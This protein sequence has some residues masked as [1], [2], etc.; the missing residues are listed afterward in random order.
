MV[1]D[2]SELTRGWSVS[3]WIEFHCKSV[4][5][6]SFDVLSKLLKSQK[7]APEDPAW[8]S[9]VSEAHLEHQWQILQS[10]S[11]KE[12]LPLYGVPIAVKDNIDV[13][14]VATTAACPAFSYQPSRDSKV[15]ELLRD[16][17]AVIIGKTNLDQF[18]TGLVGCR[19]PYGKTPCAFSDKHVSGGSSAG[20]G[21]VVARG[22]VPL[23]LGTDTAGSGRVPAAL[24]NLIG[25][26]PTKGVFSCQGVVPAC[27]SLD[28]V[29]IF[30][31]NLSNAE[32]A[33]KVMCQADERNDEYSRPYQTNPLQR[34]GSDVRVGIPNIL[35][36]FGETENPKLYASAVETLRSGGADVVTIDFE[37]L[38]ELARCLYEGAWVAERYEATKDFL[39]TNP[40]QDSLDPTVISIIKSG[41]KYSAADAFRFEYKR[42][43]ILRKVEALLATIDVLCV[44]TCPLNPTFDQVAKEPILVNSRQG[45]WTNFVNLAD[46]AALAIPAGF[47]PDGLPTGITLIGKKFTDYAL[48]DL[49]RRFFDKKYPD[50]TRNY[51]IFTEK[52]VGIK[53][54]ELT[55]PTL[56]P[57]QS[58]KLAVVGAHLKGLPLHWQLEKCNATYLSSP[59]TAKK[60]KL[61]ALPKIGPILKPGLRRVGEE[62]G[63]QIQLEL[64]S[65]PLDKFGTFMSM[66]PEPLGIGSVELESGKWVK[67]FICEE[68]GYLAKGAVDI[69]SFGG[70]KSYV[71][72]LQTQ[73]TES[74]RPFKTVLV[75]NRGEIAVRIIKTLKKLKITSVAVYSEPDKYAQH[76]LDADVAIPLHGV[77]ATETYLDMDKIIKAAK[78]TNT[79]AI[80][81]GY[82]FLSE[83]A[84]F[85]DR[86]AREG[87][88]FVGPA[89]DAIRKLGLKHSAREIAQK[90][91]VP[92]VPGSPLVS[93]AA[94]AK[95]IAA[96]LEYPIMVKSTAGGGGIGLQKVDSEDQIERV[97]ETVQHQGK[98]FFGDAGVFLERFVENARHVEIQMMGDGYGKAI[99]L[100]ERDCSLQRRNQKVVEETPAPNF[101]EKTRSRMRKAAENLGSLLKYK[102]AGTVEFIYDERRDDF[103]FLEVNARLQVEHPITEAVTGLDLVEWML[104]IAADQPMDF[105]SS[106]IN[107]TGAAIEVR[108]YAENPVKDFRPSPGQLTEVKFPEWARVD[109]WVTKGTRVSAEYDPTLA[110]I[111]VHGKDRNDAILKMNKA[112]N[113]TAVYGCVTNL[114]YLRSI[115][116]SEMFK[117]AKVA[118]KVLDSYDYKPCAFE[119]LSPGAHTSIQDYP[120]RLG[121]WRIGVPPSGPMDSYSFRLANRIVG[122]NSRAPGIEIT[123]TGPKIRFHTEAVIAITGGAAPCTVNGSEVQQFTPLTV[124][125]GDELA[126]GK[127]T[128]GCRCYLAIRSGIDVPEYLGSR[129]T[130]TLGELGGY[131]G[132]VLKLG[133]VLFLNQPG[134][135][136]STLPGPEYAPESPPT[137]LIPVITAEKEW[138]IGVTCGPHGSPD[139]FKEES[140]KQFFSDTWKVHYN[141]NRFGVRLVGPKPKWA[142]LDGGEGGLHPSNAHDYVYSIGAL[143]F[144]GDEPVIVTCDGPSLG[145]F[146]CQAV[147]AEAEMWKVGQVRPGDQIKFAPINYKVARELKESQDQA[148]STFSRT[149]LKTLTPELELP[150][151]ENAILAELPKSSDFSPKV[152][153]RQ[154]GDRYILVEYGNNEMDFNLSYRINRLIALVD[155]HKTVGIVEMSQGV[156]SV[157]IE[158]DGYKISQKDLL[159]TLIAYEN[160]IHFDNNWSVKSKIIKLP[161]AFEDSKTIACVTRY[162]E[163]IR[164]TAPWLPNNVD[165]IADVNGI[166]RDD[167]R[168]MLY[169]ARFM[170]LGLGD[171]FLSSPCAVPL[172]PRQRFLGSKYNPSRTFTERGA[173]GLGGMYMCIYAAS[174]PGGYQLVGRTIPIWDKLM[175]APNA[176][177]PW[178][179]SPFDQ[180]EFYPVS[181]KELDKFSED[182]ENGQFTVDIQDGVFDHRDYLKWVQ[183]NI[184]S[185]E[186]FQ[187]N[188][189]GEK[190]AEFAKLIQEANTE[191][192]KS[193]TS[194]PEAQ[195]DYPEGAEFVYSEYSGRFWKPIVKEGDQVKANEGLVIVEAMKTEMVVVAPA[196]GKVLKILHENGDVIDAGD[197]VAVLV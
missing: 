146:V 57:E 155:R 105:D 39:A 186:E 178:M 98:A 78:E 121:Y 15:V 196:D 160:E 9:L 48:L 102:C 43:G 77:S 111:I 117:E 122:N 28:C 99:A 140:A 53:D 151:F 138:T 51:G 107:V 191:L 171:V 87:I 163:T 165:F 13:Y 95:K 162:Q 34:Y 158:Y 131:N 142:R 41:A 89:G 64:Y 69:T 166:T 22:I 197:V 120:G 14:G 193:Q 181:E 40:P 132:R 195:E 71:N 156:R 159:K 114:D 65:V 62:A 5:S 184:E 161:M 26:K 106:H 73:E 12:T 11:C 32:R 6:A 129:S 180:I 189:V 112:L 29:S 139:F 91:G 36:W 75:A 60:Y 44:P 56:T 45:T 61:Y 153:Y 72:Y 58:I 133:D 108:L 167:V 164:S 76:V 176:K 25:L 173:V 17:G 103:Y 188:Q 33:F 35:P 115:V 92:L 81:P 145:G 88:V 63:S 49:A 20:S 94:E 148:I 83:N 192:E 134:L 66:V 3:D 113:E 97:F 24:N 147:V 126:I 136:A 55:G 143:N 50:G 2:I 124:K 152:T 4:P 80:I 104:R 157:L 172:D 190:S 30:A 187:T 90:A 52:H 70:F 10:K 1:Q 183:E 31:L 169:S 67:S 149:A 96:E 59:K 82:G 168:S 74:R 144:T 141:S 177:H 47:R 23:A 174:S 21:S 175:L 85:S 38:L 170:V 8:I 125:R 150:T 93:S 16:A 128:T 18:A 19:S 101:S 154:A 185:I 135:E 130:F 123:L 54:D 119:I 109:T 110:K 194:K 46:M 182:C 100:G 84:D 86:C 37:P 68:S 7:V 27:K 116:S 179:L 127:L 137:E 42:Q 118:T 79:E